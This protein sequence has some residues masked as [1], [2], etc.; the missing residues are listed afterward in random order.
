MQLNVVNRRKRRSNSPRLEKY[1]SWIWWAGGCVVAASLAVGSAQGAD[2][3]LSELDAEVQKV[4]AHTID[5]ESGVDSLEAPPGT[6]V[7]TNGGREGVSRESFELLLRKR[8][9]GTYGFYK[10]LPERSRQEIYIEYQQ[11]ASMDEVR[12]KIVDRLL[13]R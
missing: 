11:G 2:D 5:G 6:G 3:Y 13:Q 1:K 12:K 7:Q 10:K 4:E 8:Y 9:L